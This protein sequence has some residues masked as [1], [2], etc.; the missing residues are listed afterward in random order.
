[1]ADF[2]VATALAQFLA[3][4]ERTSLELPHMT[5]GQRKSTKKLL[6]S[7]PELRCESYGFGAERQL[8]IFKRRAEDAQ[9]H[10]KEIDVGSTSSPASEGTKNPGNDRKSTLPMAHEAIQVRNTFI[11]FEATSDERAVQS[12]PHGMFKRSML[13]EAADVPSG[14]DTPSTLDTPRAAIEPEAGLIPLGDVHTSQSSGLSVGAL[15]IVEGLVKVPAFNGRSAVVQ[16]WDEATGRYD[17]LLASSDGSQ[18]AK[19]KEEN[20]RMILP[21][22]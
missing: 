11:H 16:G 6:E 4:E 17:I 7:H 2:D 1:M 22:P 8:H 14:Y 13:A 15:V 5:T 20:L 9:E 18:H 3:D 21:C 19:I 12:M 10:S